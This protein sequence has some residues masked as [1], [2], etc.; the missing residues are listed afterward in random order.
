MDSN[1]FD[2]VSR[3]LAGTTS[4]RQALKLLGGGLAGGLLAGTGFAAVSNVAAQ[5]NR[6]PNLLA[7]LSW[8]GANEDGSFAGTAT[9]TQLYE[10]GAGGILADILLS[11]DAFDSEG[12]L[13]YTLVNEPLQAPMGLSQG[14]SATSLEGARAFAQG[15]SCDILNLT[16]GPIDLNLLGLVVQTNVIQIDIIAQRGPGNLL[17]NLLC[18]VAGLLDGGGGGLQGLLRQIN[19][20]LGQLLG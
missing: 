15:G 10:D 12:N 16:L 13:L 14:G 9:V 1:N 17:G 2:R 3:G 20:L 19:R 5:P 18:A 4:R 7:N 6:G 8:L 11:G